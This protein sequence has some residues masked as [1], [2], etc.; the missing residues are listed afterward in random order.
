MSSLATVAADEA[1]SRA[2]MADLSR[3]ELEGCITSLLRAVLE[4]DLGVTVSSATSQLVPHDGKAPAGGQIVTWR[5]TLQFASNGQKQV[6]HS[7]LT[8]LQS[9]RILASLFDF[10]L[11]TPYPSDERT[12]LVEAMTGRM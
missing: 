11:G 6:A 12:R 1:Q 4:R 8:F 10:Q 9:G 7:G 3:P 2:A 5:T